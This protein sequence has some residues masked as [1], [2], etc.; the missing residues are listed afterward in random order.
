MCPVV[1]ALTRRRDGVSVTLVGEAGTTAATSCSAAMR[2]H[3]DT[4]DHAGAR[5]LWRRQAGL[6]QARLATLTR[7]VTSFNGGPLART[8]S[9]P[10]STRKRYLEAIHERYLVRVG[11]LIGTC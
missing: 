7:L 10:R 11:L 5:P 8:R 9:R 3:V 6:G 1:K 4:P 2:H